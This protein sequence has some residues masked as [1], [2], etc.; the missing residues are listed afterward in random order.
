MET[1]EVKAKKVREGDFLTGLDSGYVYTDP[2]VGEYDTTIYFHDSDG[3]EGEL[4]VK[5]SFRVSVQRS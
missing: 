4:T 1:K 5:N 2:D 3:D